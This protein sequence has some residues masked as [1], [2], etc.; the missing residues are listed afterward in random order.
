MTIFNI[1]IVL[2]GGLSSDREHALPSTGCA[3]RQRA[4]ELR[5]QRREFHNVFN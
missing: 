4:T 5:Y 3:P 1:F 2:V